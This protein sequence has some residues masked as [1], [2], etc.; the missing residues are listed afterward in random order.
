ML[1]TIGTANCPKI[2]RIRRQARAPTSTEVC[3]GLAENMS[4]KD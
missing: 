4:M 1:T 3:L 2:T